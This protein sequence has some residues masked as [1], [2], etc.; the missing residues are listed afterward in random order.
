MWKV[1]GALHAGDFK[2]VNFKETVK[3]FVASDKAFSFM[4][5]IKG[6]PAY[7]KMSEILPMIKQ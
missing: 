6:T 3:D 1:T 2:S 7:E 5:T 4:N